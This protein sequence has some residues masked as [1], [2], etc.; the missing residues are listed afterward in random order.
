MDWSY[1]WPRLIEGAGT[2]F[3]VLVF[4]WFCIVIFDIP[5]L[6]ALLDGHFLVFLTLR[7]AALTGG[8]LWLCGEL[9]EGK[10]ALAKE[11]HWPNR[12]NA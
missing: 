3:K 9:L 6:L 5:P 11:L 2:S 10:A 4:I 8:M 12:R 7:G 1:W